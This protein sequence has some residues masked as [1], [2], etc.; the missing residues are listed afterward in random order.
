MNR[1]AKPTIQVILVFSIASVAV[2][3]GQN[4]EIDWHTI[5]GGGEM[6]STG[7]DYELGGTIGQS[8]ANELVMAGG[9]Y[10]LTG[11]FWAVPPCWCLADINN[12]GLR[13]G[14]DVQA[15]VDCMIATGANCVCA[16]VETDGDLDMDD[17]ATFVDDL[18]AGA[19]CPGMN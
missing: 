14:E 10:A 2:A 8:D 3:L 13:N 19:E 5:D 16:D 7:G 6:W 9:T 15:F 17:V 4:Y 18:L 12:D 1:T 11:G